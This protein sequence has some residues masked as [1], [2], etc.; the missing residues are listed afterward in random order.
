MIL[1]NWINKLPNNTF[2][3]VLFVLML[4]NVFAIFSG[5]NLLQQIIKPLFVPVFF[6]YLL[7][8]GKQVNTW[9]LAFLLFSFT[10]DVTSNITNSFMILNISSFFYCL[11]YLSL[12]VAVAKRIKKLELDKVIKTY[13]IF[14]FLINAILLYILF[15]LIK[16]YI[17]DSVEVTLFA[18]K[19]IALIVLAFVSFVDY[20]NSET[21]GSILFLI[22]VLCFAFSDVL[23]YISVYYL[24]NWSFVLLDR[25]LH[26]VGLLFLFN[27][28]KERNKNTDNIKIKANAFLNSLH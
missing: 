8:K 28:I 2:L 22:M 6:I 19:S 9:V 7:L 26:V 3:C 18:V 11:S 20:L 10:G 14:V 17:P 1:K 16:Y 23:H 5:N 13:L 12:I 15:D 24:Y 4:V 27:Y 25:V 21:K